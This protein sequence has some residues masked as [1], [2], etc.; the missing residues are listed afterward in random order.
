MK[1]RKLGGKGGKKYGGKG[2]AGGM[3]VLSISN[4]HVIWKPWR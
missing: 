2:T 4:G 1:G 3:A